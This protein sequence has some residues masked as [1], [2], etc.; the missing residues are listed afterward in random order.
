MASRIRVA[1]ALITAS[2]PFFTKLSSA[3]HLLSLYASDITTGSH[4]ITYC[5]V[6]TGF[7]DN[8]MPWSG[9]LMRMTNDAE[10]DDQ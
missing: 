2:G 3:L 7:G 5:T 4:I 9:Q 1:P 8:R 6:H 10:L